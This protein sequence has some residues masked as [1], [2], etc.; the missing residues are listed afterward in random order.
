[1]KIGLILRNNFITFFVG[2]RLITQNGKAGFQSTK[3]NPGNGF[4][5][6]TYL[7]WQMY[8]ICESRENIKYKKNGAE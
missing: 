4:Q 1:M 3:S 7:D 6:Y 8:Y 2:L 5:K